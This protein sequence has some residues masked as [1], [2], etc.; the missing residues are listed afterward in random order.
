MDAYVS[1][2]TVECTHSTG[3]SKSN[4]KKII[5]TFSVS[6]SHLS[7]VRTIKQKIVKQ[8]SDKIYCFYRHK[9]IILFLFVKQ[10]KGG[11]AWNYYFIIIN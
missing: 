11:G 10:Q 3:G 5:M 4:E 6:N 8:N 1:V 2:L 9:L 7:L